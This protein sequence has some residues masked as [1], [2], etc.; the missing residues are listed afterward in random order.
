MGKDGVLRSR[1]KHVLWP[2]HIIIQYMM[3]TQSLSR[4]AQALMAKVSLYSAL[5]QD[6][7]P[8]LDSPKREEIHTAITKVRR[9]APTIQDMSITYDIRVIVTYRLAV[10]SRTRTR[11]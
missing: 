6:I 1:S 3:L 10:E 8:Y 9:K 7:M 4:E 11:R 2:V 5:L